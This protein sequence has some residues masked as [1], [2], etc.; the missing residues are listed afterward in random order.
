MR[1]HSIYQR[2][3]IPPYAPWNETANA[4]P[5]TLAIPSTVTKAPLAQSINNL[6]VAQ[7]LMQATPTQ[8]GG[9]R[10]R[11]PCSNVQH[12]A[13]GELTSVVRC[14]GSATWCIPTCARSL[15][16]MPM[17][18]QHAMIN[19][20][21]HNYVQSPCPRCSTAPHHAARHHTPAPTALFRSLA[22]PEGLHTRWDGDVDGAPPEQEHVLHR[23]C[24]GR[25]EY[26]WQGELEGRCLELLASGGAAA[27]VRRRARRV[28]G[29]GCCVGLN[30]A[31]EGAD[32]VEHF[33]VETMGGKRMRYVKHR[34]ICS[35]FRSLY[36]SR[37]CP[38][39]PC[40]P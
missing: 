10:A 6:S 15:P 12:T 34:Y 8:P 5:T 29:R 17:P 40:T 35:V 20:Y 31:A 11:G 4:L 16:S 25:G 19:T 1:L 26:R 23:G 30:T 7:H 27:G 3:I 18:M 9:L 32:C 22:C 14:W 36:D 38:S 28:E 37:M 39:K 13:G 24:G 21:Q 33:P 2:P